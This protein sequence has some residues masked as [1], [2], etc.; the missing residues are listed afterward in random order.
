[1][2]HH[3]GLAVLVLHDDARLSGDGAPE[4]QSAAA[5]ANDILVRSADSLV[6]GATTDHGGRRDTAN[7]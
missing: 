7:S 4:V 6:G 2:G 5:E 3:D 1:M